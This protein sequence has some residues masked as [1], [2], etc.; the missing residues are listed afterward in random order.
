MANELIGTVKVPSNWKPWRWLRTDLTE[1]SYVPYGKIPDAYLPTKSLWIDAETANCTVQLPWTNKNPYQEFIGLVSTGGIIG[2]LGGLDQALSVMAE[3][4]VAVWG[5]SYANYD[6]PRIGYCIGNVLKEEVYTYMTAT[7]VDS[8]VTTVV[9]DIKEDIIWR[10]KFKRL[11]LYQG[12]IKSIQTVS[13]NSSATKLSTT[14][15]IVD[16]DYGKIDLSGFTTTIT[17]DI[18]IFKLDSTGTSYTLDGKITQKYPD[19]RF[20]LVLNSPIT[21][22]KNPATGDFYQLNKI[23]C[24]EDPYLMDGFWLGSESEGR[25]GTNSGY[26]LY[27]TSSNKAYYEGVFTGIYFAMNASDTTKPL[28]LPYG[29]KMIDDSSVKWFF[30][31]LKPTDP[32]IKYPPSDLP[33]TNNIRYEIVESVGIDGTVST[34]PKE[35]SI[36][37]DAQYQS[38]IGQT[39]LTYL[40]L[41][42]S[43]GGNPERTNF[44]FPCLK[45]QYI[46]NLGDAYKILNQV[47]GNVVDIS[48]KDI[49]NAETLDPKNNLDYKIINQFAWMIN[50]YIMG[51][52]RVRI[53]S[54]KITS[55]ANYP[56]TGNPTE[57]TI[58]IKVSGEN[59]STWVDLPPK[60]YHPTYLNP[61]SFYNR[62]TQTHSHTN[63]SPAE[64]EYFYTKHQDW[65]L[66][67]GGAAYSVLDFSITTTTPI[68]MGDSY[69]I[70]VVVKGGVSANSVG[71]NSYI[72]FD[73][74][75]PKSGS[76]DGQLNISL[77]QG[78]G[79]TTSVTGSTLCMNGYW[80]S[81]Q[82]LTSVGIDNSYVGICDGRYFGSSNN[83][84]LRN[85]D[86]TLFVS[87]PGGSP[88]LSSTFNKQKY[89]EWVVYQDSYSRKLTIRQGTLNFVD[90]PRK[91]EIGIGYP[92][93]RDTMSQNGSVINLNPAY[94]RVKNI[95]FDSPEVSTGAGGSLPLFFGLGN[96]SDYY[97]F[98]VSGK[99][100]V[101]LAPV[102]SGNVSIDYKFKGYISSP[103]FSRKYGQANGLKRNVV[104]F[105][106]S[107]KDGPINI[108]NGSV[109]NAVV[110]YVKNNQT[111]ENANFYDV[112]YMEDGEPIIIYG[113]PMGSF[114][115]PK[116][117]SSTYE[118]GKW[119]YSQNAI[120]MIGSISD[121]NIW[122][123]PSIK[124]PYGDT[125]YP[126]MIMNSVDYLSSS[127]NKIRGELLVMA[128][129]YTNDGKPYIG[130]LNMSM[131]GLMYKTFTCTPSSTNGV[132]DKFLWRPVAIVDAIINDVD[133][134]YLPP[135]DYI[136]SG[137]SWDYKDSG[138]DQFTRAIGSNI[139]NVSIN[140]EITNFGIIFSYCFN[141]G[142]NA[143]L[144]SSSDGLRV[145]CSTSGG[146]G[147]D[148]SPIILA[149]NAVSGII[150]NG[151]L[152]YITQYGL[153]TKFTNEYQ[154]ERCATTKS[155]DSNIAVK[156]LDIDSFKSEIIYS[157][158]LGAQKFSGIYNYEG[159]YKIFFYNENNLL[160]CVQ[161]VVNNWEVA[162]NF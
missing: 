66:Y 80:L 150:V 108:I 74:N 110:E 1:T 64:P 86:A 56:T 44:H 148:L 82:F 45:N 146:R 9:A 14:N 152:F 27:G 21:E 155:N 159:I 7:K 160:T 19:G 55:V 158:T 57:S 50:E 100:N 17:Y 151:R 109:K 13:D 125:Q 122:G 138:V 136:K 72:S 48:I 114:T 77:A 112:F 116:N 62:F 133:K 135:S 124:Y 15:F 141:D 107:T 43:G 113:Q 30:Y 144:F 39:G 8:V 85:D 147:W 123:C 131:R 68:K 3:P 2:A 99:G 60:N 115:I 98:L 23:L 24:I 71:S 121:G 139:P 16:L 91:T 84:A 142:V 46:Y 88:C 11:Y 10:S 78:Q 162:Q 149:K 95:E 40:R 90:D 111:I 12:D 18:K 38:Y 130:C 118:N 140:T 129:C 58:K 106:A 83:I 76:F 103:I 47:D 59:S 73:Y 119:K 70:E 54:G 22:E 31:P 42:I 153:E 33:Y 126:L 52:N 143:M 75:F 93:Y 94:D 104:H 161:G 37:T 6:T 32:T 4:S 102:P 65:I 69:M 35:M 120:M 81:P 41:E 117:S 156:Q 29:T 26:N 25:V 145:A 53:F 51:S 132:T 105:G 134:S 63:T 67:I 34:I 101:S 154:V 96:V 137:Y 92:V 157:G 128:K 79:A 20:L 61:K 97:G 28:N 5:L 49:T 127:Y 36:A 89:D 87:V